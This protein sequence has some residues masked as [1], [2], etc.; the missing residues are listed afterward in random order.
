MDEWVSGRSI[1]LEQ[2]RLHPLGPDHDTDL[3]QTQPAGPAWY[4][5]T[6]DETQKMHLSL[7]EK[8]VYKDTVT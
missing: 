7:L 2:C 5:D 8:H 1:A 4:S 3:L 6:E